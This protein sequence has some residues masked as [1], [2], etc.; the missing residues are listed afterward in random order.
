MLRITSCQWQYT[1]QDQGCRHHG[2][3][4]VDSRRI[5]AVLVSIMKKYFSNPF[6]RSQCRYRIQ[7]SY[8]IV[9]LANRSLDYGHP[10]YNTNQQRRSGMHRINLRELENSLSII[11]NSPYGTDSRHLTASNLF[12]YSKNR[13]L[14][15]IPRKLLNFLNICSYHQMAIFGRKRKLFYLSPELLRC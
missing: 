4:R 6:F 14:F 11:D 15:F 2:N 12:K 9:L 7:M 5:R 1:R 8:E 10:G 3:G 13:T